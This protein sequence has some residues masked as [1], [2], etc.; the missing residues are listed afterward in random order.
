MSDY[1][2]GLDR[3]KV[4]VLLDLYASLAVQSSPLRRIFF[5]TET[6]VSGECSVLDHVLLVCYS[7][8]SLIPSMNQMKSLNT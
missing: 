3:S 8:S 2:S 1:S 5:S 6:S 4:C 7:A